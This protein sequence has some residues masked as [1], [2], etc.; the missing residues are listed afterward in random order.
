MKQYGVTIELIDSETV[1][2]PGM[3]PEVGRAQMRSGEGFEA[4]L[5]ENTLLWPG[6]ATRMPAAEAPDDG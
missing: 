2:V 4:R 5:L 6:A 1:A 3:G